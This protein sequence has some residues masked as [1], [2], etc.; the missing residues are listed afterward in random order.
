MAWP[1]NS[2]RPGTIGLMS[3]VRCSRRFPSRQRLKRTPPSDLL[4]MICPKVS[5]TPSRLGQGPDYP[6]R[7]S[8]FGSHPQGPIEADHLTVQHHVLT[9]VFDEGGEFRRPAEPG[10]EWNRSAKRVL[11][12]LWHAAH[13]RRLENSGRDRHDADPV[14]GEFASERQGQ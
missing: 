4:L 13:H 6:Q 14:A 11:H 2:R 3:I 12:I 7:A 5:E 8:L 9:D 1:T 10:R